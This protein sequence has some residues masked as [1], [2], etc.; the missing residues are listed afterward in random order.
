MDY[1]IRIYSIRL[2]A[3]PEALG[4]RERGTMGAYQYTYARGVLTVTLPD[5][6]PCVKCIR[7]FLSCLKLSDPERIE[8]RS[9]RGELAYKS[10]R[11]ISDDVVS[12]HILGKSYA[13]G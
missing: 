3:S 8:L 13:S 1:T 9:E 7:A 12:Y 5:T 2:T 4:L 10:V 6:E 11:D